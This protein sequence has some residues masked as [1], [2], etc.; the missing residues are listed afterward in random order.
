MLI[1]QISWRLL[2]N[3]SRQYASFSHMTAQGEFHE[4]NFMCLICILAVIGCRGCHNVDEELTKIIFE[5]KKVIPLENKVGE[6]QWL[7]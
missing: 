6:E 5:R 1:T 4:K 7:S 2:K 3:Y